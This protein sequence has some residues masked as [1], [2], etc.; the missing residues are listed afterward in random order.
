MYFDEFSFYL[1]LAVLTSLSAVI[2]KIAQQVV[3]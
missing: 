2:L 1:V 3:P